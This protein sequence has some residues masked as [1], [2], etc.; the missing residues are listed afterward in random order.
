MT[1]SESKGILSDVSETALLTLKARVVESDKKDPVITDA[2]GKELLD[3]LGPAIPPEMRDRLLKR[4]MRA[5]LTSY[6]AIRARKYDDYTME[7]LERNPEGI[8]VSLGC[9]FDTR[10][11][12][13]VGEPGRYFE[14]DLPSVIELKMKLMGDEIPYEMIGASVLD[15]EWLDRIS[16]VRNDRVLFLAE[17]LVMYLKPDDVKDLLGRISGRFSKSEMV[18][19]VVTEKYTRGMWKRIVERKMRRGGGTTAGS[20]Y[21]FGVRT[22]KDLESMGKDIRVLE[23]W[24]YFEDEDIRPRILRVLGHLR[25]FSRSQWTVRL[26]IG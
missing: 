10:Y 2:K 5:S 6:I 23:E 20:S 7:F 3:K 9:G 22:G 1:T 13:A 24:S 12:R 17:G 11:W 8:V 4:K 19:E 21:D 18:T 14:L 16:S 25:M 15:E 26:R